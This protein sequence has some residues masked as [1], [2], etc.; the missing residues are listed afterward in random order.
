[1]GRYFENLEAFDPEMFKIAPS[2]AKGLDPQGRL[3]LEE[4]LGVL[5]ETDWNSS[6]RNS[7]GL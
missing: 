5:V 4:T 7:T 2:E 3:L 1:M 6:S